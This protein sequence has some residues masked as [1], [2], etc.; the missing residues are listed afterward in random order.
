MIWNNGN[1]AN[2]K[3]AVTGRG[4]AS[5]P[6]QDAISNATAAMYHASLD[7]ECGGVLKKT[8]KNS[9]KP[10]QNPIFLYA[11]VFIIKL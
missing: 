1:K 2:G 6:H 7:I 10:T 5:V 3:R 9:I 8:P 11:C 4:I